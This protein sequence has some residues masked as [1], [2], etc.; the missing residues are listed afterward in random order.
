M[1]PLSLS[2]TPCRPR[3]PWNIQQYHSRYNDPPHQ[4]PHRRPCNHTTLHL[5]HHQSP[6]QQQTRRR[7]PHSSPQ[8]C[9]PPLTLTPSPTTTAATKTARATT[10]MTAL[11]QWTSHVQTL[12]QRQP[13]QPRAQHRSLPRPQN[14]TRTQHTQHTHRPAQLETTRPLIPSRPQRRPLMTE[15]S[16]FP[17]RRHK[18][19]WT[20]MQFQMCP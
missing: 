8:P 13:I 16:A 12:I 15:A 6:R 2:L 1:S 5:H 9:I 17:W 7:C 3:T 18:H 14:T 4:Q 20:S 19:T 10:N 11:L